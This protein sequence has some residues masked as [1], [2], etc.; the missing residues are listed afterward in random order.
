[1]HVPPPR[2]TH[3]LHRGPAARATQGVPMSVYKSFGTRG[4]AIIAYQVSLLRGEVFLMNG[5]EEG[6]E[7]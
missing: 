4:E 2:L 6:G 1:M 7:E 3:I 5:K